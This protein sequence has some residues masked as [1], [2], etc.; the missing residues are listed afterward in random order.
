M[1]STN[2]A[3]FS[4]IA[5][6]LVLS[7]TQFDPTHGFSVARCLPSFFPAYLKIFHPI[8]VDLNISDQKITWDE[9]EKSGAGRTK[10][11][12]REAT[13][14]T[15]S[16][17]DAVLFASPYVEPVEDTSRIRWRDLAARYGLLFGP[18]FNDHSYRAAFAK[19][20]P[21]YLYGP[22]EGFLELDQYSPLTSVLSRHTEPQFIYLK[23][24]D[25]WKVGEE[26]DR[27]FR[28]DINEVVEFLRSH[29]PFQSPEYLWPEDRSWCVNSDY[30]LN[31]T[32]IAGT[33]DLILA[34]SHDEIL[35]TIPVTP[36][37][38]VDYLA[39]RQNLQGAALGRA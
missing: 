32:L 27:I 14:D 4:W 36:E 31:F 19:S 23:M 30:D 2:A 37:T 12:Y 22:A 34:L 26:V 38:R 20:W 24:S 11:A 16:M 9:W 3:N 13:A 5:K 7:G 6:S 15:K 8:F 25:M 18:E 39:D 33:T 29:S 28:G 10:Y 21:R 1:E 35:E 17:T